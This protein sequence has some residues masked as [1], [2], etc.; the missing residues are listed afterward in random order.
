MR[1]AVAL[2]WWGYVLVFGAAIGLAWLAYA[3]SG[4]PA[5]SPRRQALTALRAA[6]LV[7]IVACLLRPVQIV[8]ASARDSVVPILVDVSRSM[9]LADADGAPRLDRARA[10]VETLAPALD[11]EFRTE[12]LTFGEALTAAGAEPLAATG[13]RSD[14]SGALASTLERYR[15]QAIAGIVVISDGGDTESR[16]RAPLEQLPVPVYAIG[17]GA[18]EAGR[19]REVVNVTAGEPLLA[20]SSIELSVSVVSH[21]FGVDPI[22]L[23]VLANGRPIEVRR[24]VPA[25]DGAPVH[26]VFTVSPE[27]GAPTVYAV[28][29]PVAAGELVV[30]NNTRSVIVPPSGRARRVL[31]VEGAPGYE[32]TFLKR[33]LAADRGLE[34][35]AVIRKGQNDE[36]RDTFFVQAAASRAAAL[37]AGYPLRRADL[38]AYDAVIFGN[39]EGGFFTREQLEMTADFVAMRGGGLLVLGARSFDQQGLV[40]TPLEEV[41]PVELTDRRGGL[42]RASTEGARGTPGALLLTPE[43]GLHAVTRIAATVEDSRRRWGAL[44]PLASVAPIGGPRPGAQVLAVTAGVGGDPR[45]LLAVQRYGQG[46][47]MVFAGEATWRWRMLAPAADTT[48]ETVWRQM[49]RWLTAAAPDPV[50]LAPFEAAM[51]GTTETVSV[52]VRD[53]EFAPVRDAE[54]AMRITLP[55]GGER[56]VVA[57]LSHPEEGRYSASVRLDTEGVYR[58]TAE[59]RRQHELI[60]TATHAALVGGVD[61][62]MADPRLNE[63][64]LQRLARASGGEVMAAGDAGAILDRL[65]ASRSA[66][67]TPEVRDLWNTGWM[68]VVII[69]L[70]AGE[71]VLRRRTGLV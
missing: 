53:G 67:G 63:Q 62:E 14:L 5:S 58:V 70:L 34:V 64:V 16:D 68:L 35:D 31:I 24:V 11:A 7:L 9:R 47:A 15:G 28:D 59:A 44:P 1:F 32:H 66:S 6:T 17:V 61:L 69:L 55:G 46:R 25:A 43:G 23:R 26:A 33:A 29:I 13:R 52:V 2:P 65:R 57:A 22:D 36:N 38:F 30:E 54:V 56:Q 51:P 45:P 4:L 20:D 42:A 49:A 37:A 21:G 10:L 27:P 3:R 39:I 8:P 12:V 60:G 71:W 48:Y 41:L 50:T 18:A 40:G 19:D